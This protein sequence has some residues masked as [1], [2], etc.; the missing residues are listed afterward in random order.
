MLDNYTKFQ[1]AT[2]GSL[3]VHELV[4]FLACLPAFLFQFIPFMRRFKIQ[5]DRPETVEKQWKCLKLILFNH[6]CIQL[7]LIAGT[8][9]L[10]RCLVF[11][12]TGR[13]CPDGTCWL[14]RFSAVQ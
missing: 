12:T 13:A 14:L 5:N 10:R 11:H 6:F 7:P 1:I 8:Y 4:Y 2:W 3:I 9:V